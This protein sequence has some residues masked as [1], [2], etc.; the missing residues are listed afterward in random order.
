[1][2]SNT[3]STELPVELG[4]LASAV[5]ALAAEDLTRLP[6]AQAAQRVLALR[7]LLERLEG[8]WLR[9]L[10]AV[11]AR[12]AAG[13]EQ[14]V[15]ASST[16]G[17]L[18]RHARPLHQR[19]RAPFADRYAKQILAELRHSLVAQMLLMFEINHRRSQARTKTP[20]AVQSHRQLPSGHPLTVWTDHLRLVR[21]NHHRRDRG[22]FGQLVPEYGLRL[23]ATQVGLTVFTALDPRLNNPVRLC[24][25]RPRLPCMPK[26]RPVLLALPIRREVTFHI[27]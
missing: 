10:A 19:A 7:G 13:A 5:E 2:D 8:Q 17:W 12:G 24:H 25:P 1:M 23:Y 4:P 16:A 15:Q 11:D 3:G 22:D 26:G 6:D 27:S 9:E 20:S 14:G 18:R 21:L